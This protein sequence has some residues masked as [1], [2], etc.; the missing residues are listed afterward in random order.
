[1]AAGF[2]AA[3]ANAQ[4]QAAETQVAAARQ[5]CDR[6]DLLFKQGAMAKREFDRQKSQCTSQLFQAN[7]AR[8]NADL[9]GKLAGDTIIR[10][11]IDGVIGERYVNVGE[12]VQPSTRVASVFSVNP[13]RISISVPEVVVS[14]VH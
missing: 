9:A 12:Y 1:K 3:A 14:Q 13:V 7:A 2:Q 5:D 11:P 6:A 4:S 10:A 8:A